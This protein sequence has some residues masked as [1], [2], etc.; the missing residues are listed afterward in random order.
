MNAAKKKDQQAAAAEQR[1]QQKD[2]AREVWIHPLQQSENEQGSA[3]SKDNAIA[4]AVDATAAAAA[5]ASADTTSIAAA[6]AKEASMFDS[7]L[8]RTVARNFQIR[9]L[10]LH[11]K[12]F[13]KIG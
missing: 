8:S 10:N 5:A 3:V 2:S 9:F 6:A 12:L 4:A 13:S 7:Q 11:G 1:Q